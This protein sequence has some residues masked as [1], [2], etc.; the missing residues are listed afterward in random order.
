MLAYRQTMRLSSLL[1]VGPLVLSL[2]AC[3]DDTAGTGGGGGAGATGAGSTGTGGPGNTSTT[4]QGTTASGATSIATG[5]GGTGEGGSGVGGDAAG[6]N[7]AGGDGG[8]EGGGIEQEVGPDGAT[9]ETG[10]VRVTIPEGALTETLTIGIHRLDAAAIASLPGFDAIDGAT[11]GALTADVFAFTPHGTTFAMAVTIELPAADGQT[12]LRLDDESD[13]TWDIVPAVV[14]GGSATYRTY[15]FSIGAVAD[16]EGT[17]GCDP[18]ECAELEG[19]ECI[20]MTLDTSD[21][22]VGWQCAEPCTQ[23]DQCEF[24]VACVD[25]T[26][27]ML[28]GW[29]CGIA[30]GHASG[31]CSGIVGHNECHGSDG[32]SRGLTLCVDNEC[33][34]TPAG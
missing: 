33:T 2:S 10:G 26:T 4:G 22:E 30:P 15:G 16:V 25:E 12:I 5:Q 34:D 7:G 29:W 32:Q 13:S 23:D 20:Y 28:Y 24:P 14:D 11:S 18:V 21:T 9:L 31:G 6:G 3:G 19:S 8:A 17:P 1:L 27:Q